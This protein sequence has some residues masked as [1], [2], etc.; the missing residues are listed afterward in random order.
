MSDSYNDFAESPISPKVFHERVMPTW[1]RVYIEVAARRDDHSLDWMS[2]DVH[3]AFVALTGFD[4]WRAM[5]LDLGAQVAALDAAHEV[6]NALYDADEVAQLDGQPALDFAAGWMACRDIILHS[7]VGPATL[8]AA[9]QRSANAVGMN[10]VKEF[11]AGF[12]ARFN[13]GI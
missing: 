11:A 7:H 3:K 8:E 2:D 4:P 10:N 6:G 9:L 13:R 5:Y 12:M 1:A